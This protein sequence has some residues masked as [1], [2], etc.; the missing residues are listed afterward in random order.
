MT[1]AQLQRDHWTVLRFWEHVAPEEV[2][3]DIIKHI[4]A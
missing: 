1:N 3:V 4:E 2:V